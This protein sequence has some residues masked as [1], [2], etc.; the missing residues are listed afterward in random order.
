MICVLVVDDDAGLRDM[1]ARL[2][3]VAGYSAVAAASG[4]QALAVARA[5]TDIDAA[6]I[7]ITLPDMS[8]FDLA[9]QLRRLAPA[10][11]VAFMSGFTGDDFRRP[12]DAPVVTK[13]F[14]LEE[15]TR[16]LEQALAR[17]PSDG[18]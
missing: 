5:R 15:L 1:A 14:T 18:S 16:G 7:D 11:R 4:T 9:R 8:G 10:V 3:K 6:L 17:P 13:P 12:V 2:L